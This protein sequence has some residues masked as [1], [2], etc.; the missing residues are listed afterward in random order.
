MPSL[1]EDI[2]EIKTLEAQLAQAARLEGLD[3]A[4]AGIAYEINT[5]IQYVGDSVTFQ[6][7]LRKLR[8]DTLSSRPRIAQQ[9]HNFGTPYYLTVL[10]KDADIDFIREEAPERSPSDRTGTRKIS[11]IIRAMNRFSRCDLSEKRWLT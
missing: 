8:K 7:V 4:G 9:V 10:L 11:S 5:P 6:G 1:G 3:T 2:T